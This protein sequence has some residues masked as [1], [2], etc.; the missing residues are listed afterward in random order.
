MFILW[1]MRP[2]Q[3]GQMVTRLSWLV[4][5]NST[6]DIMFTDERN[7]LSDAPGQDGPH[8]ELISMKWTPVVCIAV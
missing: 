7:G 8:D 5:Y 1:T 6:V 2:G 3:S 4:L